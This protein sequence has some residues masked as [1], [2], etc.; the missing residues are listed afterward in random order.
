M[1]KQELSDSLS[2][3]RGISL[4]TRGDGMM[5][6]RGDRGNLSPFKHAPRQLRVVERYSSQ[7]Y[8]AEETV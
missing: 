3:V 1:N 4:G 8:V 7:S 5:Q 2:P 6:I